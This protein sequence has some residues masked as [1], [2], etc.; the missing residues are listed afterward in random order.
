MNQTVAIVVTYNRKQLLLKCI[1][2][3]RHQEGAHKTDILVI[4]NA[5]TDGTKEALQ[6]LIDEEAI[7]YENTGSNLG[8]AGGFNYGIK[9]AVQR[10]YEY[11]WIMDDDTIAHTDTLDKLFKAAE[12]VDYNFGFLSSYAKWI[13]GNA[14]EMNVPKISLTWRE[15]IDLMD[16]NL[17]RLDSASFVSFFTKASVVR[18]VGLP[19]KEFFIWADDVEYSLRISKKYPSYFVYD[20]Q[21]THEMGSNKATTIWDTDPD[22]LGRFAY[23]Y[24]NRRY[25]VNHGMKRDRMLFRID[26]MNTMKDIM[27]S[28]CSHK[29]KRVHIVWR[30]YRKGKRFN[31]PIEY[32]D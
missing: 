4:D 14:C 5:S 22:R 28:N 7:I 30:S 11:L 26:I 6:A 18:E 20:S 21:V 17:I 8:G 16:K 31:P 15:N 23:L 32:V 2:A 19:I 24:R 12:A 1:E 29:W 3:L 25:I 13:D 27:K 10:G 9:R